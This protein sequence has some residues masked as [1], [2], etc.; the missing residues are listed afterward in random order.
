MQNSGHPELAKSLCEM[1][2]KAHV[3]QSEKWGLDHGT[4]TILHR[5][6][7]EADIPVVQLSIDCQLGIP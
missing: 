1:I 5:M 2:D 4:W 3:Q 6:Y 7:P